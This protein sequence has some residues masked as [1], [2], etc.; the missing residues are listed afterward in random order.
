MTHIQKL[1]LVPLEEW[2]KLRPKTSAGRSM[3]PKAMTQQEGRGVQII[4]TPSMTHQPTQEVK[5]QANQATAKGKMLPTLPS[6][7]SPSEKKMETTQKK[8]RGLPL[9]MFTP[10]LRKGAL[11]IWKLLSQ[12]GN[13]SITPHMEILVK[14]ERIPDSNIISLIEHALS[15]KSKQVLPAQKKFYSL[16]KYLHAPKLLVKN[17]YYL[18]V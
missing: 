13:I 9:D 14:D 18:T 11:K 3:L 12:K 2:E 15:K 6:Q 17:P 1:A 10:K 8:L 4:Q 16:L 7:S 5:P